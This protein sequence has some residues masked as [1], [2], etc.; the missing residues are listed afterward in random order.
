MLALCLLFSFLPE[1]K[2]RDIPDPLFVLVTN[3]VPVRNFSILKTCLLCSV[4]RKR[5]DMKAAL[6]LDESQSAETCRQ[7]FCCWMRKV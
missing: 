6:H 7:Q 5:R 3:A 4:S 2:Q 1:W